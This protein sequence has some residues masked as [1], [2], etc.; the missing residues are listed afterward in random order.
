M[1]QFEQL[2]IVLDE[3]LQELT[4]LWRDIGLDQATVQERKK[5]VLNQFKNITD[6]MLNEEKSFK[7][8]LLESLEHHS[9]VCQ[10]L[11]KEMGV[12][13]DEPD[14]HLSLLELQQ[15]MKAEAVK[16]G[17]MKEERMKEVLKLKKID[18]DICNKICMDPYYVSSTT[19]PTTAQLEGLKDHIRRMDEEKFDREEKYIGM[20][21][22]ILRLYTELEEEPMSD[23]EREVACEETERF[24]LSSTNLAQVSD[25]LKMLENQVK[26]NQKSHMEMVEKIGSLYER[27]RLDMAEKYQ[28]LSLHQGHGKSVLAELKD[29]VDRLEEMKKANIESFI[30]NLRNELHA[31]WDECF[32]SAKQR[33]SFQALHSID[34]TEDLLEQHEAELENMKAYLEQNRDL[35]VKVKE[36][37][38]VWSKFM[39]LER[40]A[41]DPTRLMNSRGNQLLQEEK[42][43][44]KVNK[45]LPRIEQELHDL[46]NQWEQEQGKAFKVEG[47]SFAA[48]IEQQKE[49]HI[50]GLEMEKIAREKAK[51]ENLLHETR[52]GA[53]PVTPRKLHNT[54][55]TPRKLPPTPLSKSKVSASTSHL[56]R[57]VSSAVAT[58]RSPRAGRI[59]KG[60]SPRLGGGAGA[61]KKKDIAANEKKLRKGV[62]TESNYTLV[63]KSVLKSQ[64]GQNIS[65]ASTVPDYGSFKK[66]DM[67]NST[68]AMSSL[69]PEVTTR[70][71]PSYMTPT[72]SATNK[73]FK[74]PTSSVSR[75][76]LG[77]PKSMSKSTPQ[78]SR[79]R[80]GKNLPM[81]F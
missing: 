67:L 57:K 36:R 22:A 38:E 61:R 28:F 62:L 50:R 71:H 40:R 9:R 37:Q 32:Y 7:T 14:A 8:R 20:K 60:V 63:N 65:M 81:L 29:E 3:G 52:F 56:V 4:T 30:N 77:T 34:F 18:E 70:S 19:V 69:T 16:L 21:E 1:E 5:T 74:T 59:A 46:I 39:E 64:G 47:V 23:M 44:N 80:S 25:I 45:A 12:S 15:A 42:E 54:T 66:G 51:K 41:K 78:L 6:R 75:S 33:E 53:K 79:L 31:I 73:M 48:F 26:K 24:V 49:D 76:R 27:L 72:A 17:D 2:Q 55:K 43:R 10:K 11:S 35:F 58:M 68:E 13:Y